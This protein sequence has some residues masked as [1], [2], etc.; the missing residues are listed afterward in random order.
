MGGRETSLEAAAKSGVAD[1]KTEAEGVAARAETLA[2][3]AKT[4]GEQVVE[5][6]KSKLP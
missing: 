6:V 1:A 4:K 3:D 5:K 2:A